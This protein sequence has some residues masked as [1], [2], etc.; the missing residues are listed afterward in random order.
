MVWAPC[1]D[2]RQCRS[3]L[4]VARR[5]GLSGVACRA[6]ADGWVWEVEGA[7]LERLEVG[8]CAAVALDSV[9]GGF[10]SSWDGRLVHPA[11]GGGSEGMAGLLAP[12]RPG[13]AARGFAASSAARETRGS[14]RSGASTGSRGSSGTPP[15]AVVGRE[16][17]GVVGWLEGPRWERCRVGF[18]GVRQ[19]LGVRLDYYGVIMG[20]ASMGN[21]E[22]G[23]S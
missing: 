23:E 20:A 6:Y 8:G 1:G 10:G 4:S 14:G 17:C 18:L 3:A 19:F 13:S 22:C 15:G 11:A 2:P 16:A 7:V 21:W 12:R 5:T 9:G